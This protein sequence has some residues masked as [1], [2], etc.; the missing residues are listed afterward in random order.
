[1]LEWKKFQEAMR[2]VSELAG[3]APVRR[4]DRNEH[5]VWWTATTQVQLPL[6]DWKGGLR[7]RW[8]DVADKVGEGWLTTGREVGGLVLGGE[9]VVT[10][11]FHGEPTEVETRMPAGQG[12]NHAAYMRAWRARQVAAGLCPKCGDDPPAPDRSYC[13]GCLQAQAAKGPARKVER[14]AAGLCTCGR[15]PAP[16]GKRC[17]RCRRRHRKKCRRQHARR[18]PC[19]SCGGPRPRCLHSHDSAGMKCSWCRRGAGRALDV[20]ADG[21]VTLT[22]LATREGS[23]WRT[24]LRHVQELVRRGMAVSSWSVGRG[25]KVYRRAT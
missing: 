1:M 3:E 18:W 2:L 13:A 19:V 15:T 25:A 21:P 16:G 8:E 20:L 22:E 11:T 17:A 7:A 10:F 23:C 9:V 4:L 14:R 6:Q 5:R 12:V 24:A